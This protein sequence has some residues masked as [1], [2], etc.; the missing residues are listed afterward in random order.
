MKKRG[1][2]IIEQRGEIKEVKLT[3]P[4][5]IKS[6]CECVYVQIN[7]RTG[8]KSYSSEDE[9]QVLASGK[10]DPLVE[11]NRCVFHVEIHIPLVGIAPTIGDL[12]NRCLINLATG[13]C[14]DRADMVIRFISVAR[15]MPPDWH[16]KCD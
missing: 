4:R 5:K 11:L 10:P 7:K 6:G 9:A 14:G 3:V 16:C 13:A 12:E 2:Y 15:D 1:V 8:I